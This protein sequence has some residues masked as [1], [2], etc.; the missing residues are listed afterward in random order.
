MRS[1]CLVVLLALVVAPMFAP[2]S[3]AGQEPVGMTESPE[4]LSG[5]QSHVR[6]SEELEAFVRDRRMPELRPLKVNKT[7]EWSDLLDSG[8]ARNEEGY[9]PF[10][11]SVKSKIDR[12][13][14]SVNA[15]G[16]SPELRRSLAQN[17]RNDLLKTADFYIQQGKLSEDAYKQVGASDFYIQEMKRQKESVLNMIEEAVIKLKPLL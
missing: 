7:K 14:Q 9:G 2:L 3:F 5:K 8:I 13:M 1:F 11:R 6:T 15:D 16:L 17:L 4:S 12:G 10:E